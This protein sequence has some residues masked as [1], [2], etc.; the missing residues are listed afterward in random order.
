[1]KTVIVGGAIANKYLKGGSVWT[2]LSYACGLQK[3]GFDVYFVEQIAPDQCVDSEGNKASFESS[4]NLAFFRECTAK[5]GLGARAV[6]MLEGGEHIDGM[7]FADLLDLAESAE[8]LLNISGHL[9]DE[10]LLSR[11]RRKVFIDQDPGFTQFWLA[12]GEQKTN[13][14][15]HDD[16]FTIGENIGRAGCC[17]PTC[18]IHWRPTRQPI[19]LD[20][21]PVCRSERLE[22]FTTIGSWRGSYG[23]VEYAGK[24]YGLKVHE[25]RK[26]LELPTRISAACEIALDIH[27]ADQK[28]E[29]RLRDCGWKL[30]DPR[31]V[32]ADPFAFR[33]YVQTSDAEFSVAQGTY[34]ETGS[35]WFSD[36]TVRYLA[37]GKPALVQDTGFSSNYPFGEGVVAFSTLEEAVDGAARLQRNYEQHCTAA[38]Q[39][40][41]EFFDSDKVLGRMV[42]EMDVSP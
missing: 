1:M 23:I 25:F 21:W 14:D 22:R 8:F 26:F 20:H 2:R 39:F 13:L 9:E 3:L 40:A 16:Y 34:V 4:A 11:I 7:T 24:T 17:I 28:D 31:S 41:E 27:A 12:N 10:R 36:R 29:Q 35:G 38:R 15:G 42:D 33:R 18:G 37:T 32:A 5:F 30:V 6:L 19:V